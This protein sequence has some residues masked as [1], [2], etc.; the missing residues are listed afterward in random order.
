MR[1]SPTTTHTVLTPEHVRTTPPVVTRAS[2]PI[3]QASGWAQ[4]PSSSD[5]VPSHDKG[6]CAQWPQAITRA[7]RG[8][9]RLA[10]SHAITAACRQISAPKPGPSGTASA[11]CQHLPAP[12]NLPR[13][14]HRGVQELG[15]D[16]NNRL[17]HVAA[18]NP[19]LRGRVRMGGS[20]A[21]AARRQGHARSLLPVDV[22]AACVAHMQAQ[23]VPHATR[24]HVQQAAPNRTSARHA[25]QSAPSGHWH[26]TSAWLVVMLR[27]FTVAATPW[28]SRMLPNLQGETCVG[29]GRVGHG[30]CAIDRAA[31]RTR[32]ISV[33]IPLPV[34]GP[35]C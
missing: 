30:L 27:T 6:R 13:G 5:A 31:V 18:H 1:G 24:R 33:D 28:R 9:P 22:Q 16:L 23:T 7:G 29:D 2:Y 10:P 20:G 32:S 17:G 15:A 21:V 8:P 19:C 25:P 3:L 34:L 26:C 4:R 14:R 11:V 12:V 35:E